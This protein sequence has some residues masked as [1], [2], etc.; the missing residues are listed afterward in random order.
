MW[1]STMLN[2]WLPGMFIHFFWSF[3]IGVSYGI[4]VMD[5]LLCVILK[6]LFPSLQATV[7]YLQA[8]VD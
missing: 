2:V 1:L 4:F 3:F 5:D 7:D 6:M 8:T